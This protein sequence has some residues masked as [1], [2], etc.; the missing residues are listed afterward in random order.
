MNG[1]FERALPFVLNIEG[2]YSDDPNDS[3]GKTNH[4]ITEA[5]ARAHGYRGRMEDL[6]VALAKQWYR[7]DYWDKVRADEIK[8]PMCLYLFDAAVQH[9]PPAAIRLVQATLGLAQ[10]AILGPLTL[11]AVNGMSAEQCGL[12]LADRAIHYT[13]LAKFPYYGRGWLKRM[14]LMAQESGG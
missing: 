12:A 13:R 11:A 2:G 10:D 7:E 9:S 1:D 4:G 14:F 6:S 8:W 5:V 3:G